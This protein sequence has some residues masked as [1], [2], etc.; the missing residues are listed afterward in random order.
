M[1]YKADGLVETLLI[2]AFILQLL[3]L[4]LTFL[5]LLRILVIISSLCSDV[6]WCVLGYFR[7]V[8]LIVFILVIISWYQFTPNYDY[9]RRLMHKIHVFIQRMPYKNAMAT[10]QPQLFTITFNFFSQV[11]SSIATW[12]T[13]NLYLT[14][15][16]LLLLKSYLLTYL[17]TYLQKK[18]CQF[19]YFHSV[20]LDCVSQKFPYFQIIDSPVLLK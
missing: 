8:L 11:C 5:L 6:T 20:R 15:V 10:V 4:R 9:F 19:C 13:F 16:C 2:I 18:T 14:V 1:W 3:V 7:N 12:F 17:L